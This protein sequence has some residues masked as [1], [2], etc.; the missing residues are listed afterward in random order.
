MSRVESKDKQESG[1]R[2]HNQRNKSLLLL[3]VGG[4]RGR[5]RGRSAVE[6]R[7]LM[8]HRD[9]VVVVSVWFVVVVSFRFVRSD[10]M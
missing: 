3:L 8:L 7:V 2:E 5:G 10:F 1:E 9:T 4:G 6:C